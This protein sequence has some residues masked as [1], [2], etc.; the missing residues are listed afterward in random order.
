MM[1]PLALA[2][3]PFVFKRIKPIQ[4]LFLLV[5]YF[6]GI[7]ATQG[8]LLKGEILSE[9]YNQSSVTIEGVVDDIPEKKNDR[10]Q[11]RIKAKTIMKASHITT[12]KVFLYVTIPKGEENQ[13]LSPGDVVRMKGN[14]KELSDQRNPGGFNERLYHQSKGVSG[15]FYEDVGSLEKIG[16]EK[17]FFY[18]ILSL[19]LYLE[20]KSEAYL[21]QEVNE[22]L[23][24]TILGEKGIDPNIRTDFKKAGV[25]HVLSVSGLHVGYLF[26]FLSL[27]LTVLKIHKKLWIIFLLPILLIYCGLVGFS[28]SVVRASLMLLSLV[29]GK[30]WHKEKDDL[31]NL[32]LSG[33]I[34]LLI[35]PLQVF[36]PGFQLS[37]AAVLGIILFYEPLMFQYKK[38]VYKK[39]MHERIPNK[40]L[41]GII[42]SFGVMIGTTPVLLAHFNSM[43]L[44]TFFSNVIIVPLIGF[45][46]F[47][48]FIFFLIKGPLIGITVFLLN[49]LGKLI[50][51][52]LDGIN[53]FSENLGFL[54]INRGSFSL[55]EFLLFVFAGFTISGYFYLKK[56]E[57]KFSLFCLG[58]LLTFLLILPTFTEK[59]LLVTILDV[60]QGDAILIETPNGTN[61]LIDGGGYYLERETEIS[62]RIL[63][64][65]LYSKNI[66]RLD[67][68]FLTHNH[69][70][71]VQGIEELIKNG[72]Q[73]DHLFMSIKTNN[74]EL[75][76]QDMVETILLKKGSV[77]QGKDGVKLEVLNPEGEIKMIDESQQN[78]TS[79]VI[80]LT[81]KEVKILFCGDIESESE[82]KL[83]KEA[84]LGKHQIIKIPHHGSNTSTTEAFLK[85]VN[86]DLALIS[87]GKN[88]TFGHP[89]KEVIERINNLGTQILRTDKNGAIEIKS[90]GKRLAYK[91]F[92][93]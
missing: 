18:V 42:L 25:S 63:K 39:K 58:I 16:E 30:G 74:I 41:Q 54:V 59:D 26:L 75:M 91:T 35:W 43:T 36:Q 46:L 1:I 5:I 23:K 87:V 92:G 93:D 15:L 55:P 7:F 80:R 32:C 64:P 61:Y 19:K 34:I 56:K 51:I 86:P 40:F 77:I 88:N 69:V 44:I 9:F 45:F 28:S 53:T 66:R 84:S 29:I 47:F 57:I 72:F 22:L 48:G 68:V 76:N 24:G 11:F 71:H 17:S 67:G 78:N 4:I 38:I 37:F 8:L 79:L 3:L 12:N 31:S 49:F 13:R 83:L 89:R 90:N 82:R 85:E 81:Y 73:I 20:N 60:G 65:A 21:T 14:I 52:S 33:I 6:S 62:E 50:F 27:I 10:I 2:P 70:D